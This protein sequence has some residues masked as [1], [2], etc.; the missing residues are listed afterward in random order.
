MRLGLIFA[1]VFI[2]IMLGMRM[3]RSKNDGD[4]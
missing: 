3:L 2:V 4:R 1:I